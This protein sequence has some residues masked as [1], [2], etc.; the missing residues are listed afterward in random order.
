MNAMQEAAPVLLDDPLHEMARQLQ[1]AQAA[2]AEV[3]RTQSAILGALGH[4]LRG[5]LTVILGFAQLMDDSA[6]PPTARQKSSL[7][8]IQAAGWGL[9]ALIDEILDAASVECGKVP[10]KMQDV[11][12][13]DVLRDCE[14][15]VEP[16]A[17]QSSVRFVFAWP[18]QP[19]L[20]AADRDRLQ[21][22]LMALLGH[23]QLNSGAEGVVRV[24]C[25]RCGNGR[26]R[27]HFQDT[28]GG[29]STAWLAQGDPATHFKLILSQ[30]LA[31]HMG[32]VIATE[33]A[34][35]A[36]DASTYWLELNAAGRTP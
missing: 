32:G 26:V 34:G 30:Q 35:E 22:V 33:C 20:V 21:Q 31:G 16:S 29:Q 23:A 15:R 9:L 14:T 11:S 5:P 25:H 17:R 8:Q 2:L 7:S 13:E 6:P 18:A 27:V 19:L 36:G 28:S 24:G 4:E 3:Q 10:L 1:A 12:I